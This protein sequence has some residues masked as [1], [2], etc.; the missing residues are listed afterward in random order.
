MQA[1]FV[2]KD[3]IDQEESVISKTYYHLAITMRIYNKVRWELLYVLSVDIKIRKAIAV[4]D[5]GKIFEALILIL[6]NQNLKTENEDK[7]SKAFENNE[8]GIDN[9]EEKIVG[10]VLLMMKDSSENRKVWISSNGVPIIAQLLENNNNINPSAA[11]GST[12]SSCSKFEYNLAEILSHLSLEDSSIS[13]FSNSEAIIATLCKKLNS[14]ISL[15]NNNNNKLSNNNNNIQ[16]FKISLTDSSGSNGGVMNGKIV[17]FLM[18][19]LTRIVFSPR[20]SE[21]VLTQGIIPL[22]IPFLEFSDNNNKIKMLQ[23]NAFKDH[24]ESYCC[25]QIFASNVYSLTLFIFLIHIILSHSSSDSN[26]TSSSH[27]VSNP[28]SSSSNLYEYA[29]ECLLRLSKDPNSTEHIPEYTILLKVI[30]S[31]L[32]PSN[33]TDIQ[34][35][36]IKIVM[37]IRE[38]THNE[39]FWS[40]FVA[41]VG[42]LGMFSFLLTAISCEESQA[43]RASSLEISNLSKTPQNSQ[44][45]IQGDDN[46][47]SSNNNLIVKLMEIE[48]GTKDLILKQNLSG[49]ISNLTFF[50]VEALPLIIQN[51]G[52][53]ILIDL[54]SSSV[55]SSSSSQEQENDEGGIELSTVKLNAAIAL[56]NIISWFKEQKNEGNERRD[57]GAEVLK[58]ENENQKR[59]FWETLIFLLRG[60]V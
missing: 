2:V 57:E 41:S 46:E 48:Q 38:I 31:L 19:I 6:E 1:W 20:T 37:Q 25:F 42:I 23:E 22:L 36:G 43:Q 14:V 27:P 56:Y 11:S 52:I 58:F 50:K 60:G 54:F 12:A 24:N 34:K 4:I 53:P 5:N 44:R 7:N 35:S 45:L 16:N 33:S 40:E 39:T 17:Q 18:K 29:V 9:L 26:P 32:H 8:R 10:I 49:V 28:S 59:R 13:I 47:S 30:V 55:H 51:F 3:S 21:I 15:I